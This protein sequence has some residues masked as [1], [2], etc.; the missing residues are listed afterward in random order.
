MRANV[1][2]AAAMARM[3][4]AV[5]M[6]AVTTKGGKTVYNDV[7]FCLMS[8]GNASLRRYVVLA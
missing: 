6:A 5:N 4:M 8:T 3:A 1:T 2:V 7:V